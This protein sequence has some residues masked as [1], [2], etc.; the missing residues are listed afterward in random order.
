MEDTG[1][2]NAVL[3][4]LLDVDLRIERTIHPLCRGLG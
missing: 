4:D 1:K 2:A 3:D